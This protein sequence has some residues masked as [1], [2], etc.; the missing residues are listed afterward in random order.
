MSAAALKKK[1]PGHGEAAS[2]AG[3]PQA[4]GEAAAAGVPAFLGGVAGGA[5]T[6]AFLQR[7]P[8]AAAIPLPQSEEEAALGSGSVQ[9]LPQDPFPDSGEEDDLDE[10][11]AAIQTKLEINTPG[12]AYEREADRVAAAVTGKGAAS[13]AVSAASTAP[14]LQRKCANCDAPLTEE[15]A[16]SECSGKVQRKQSASGAPSP[17]SRVAQVVA[18]P[19]AGRP[20]PDATRA[21]IEAELG[22]DLSHVRVHDDNAAGEASSSIQAKAFTHKNH[23]WLGSGQSADD[24]ALMAHEA[25][26]TVQQS[27]GGSDPDLVQ[28]A[29]ADHQHPEDGAAPKARMDAEIANAEEDGEGGDW[30]EGDPLPAVDQSERQSKAGSLEGQARP[31]TDRPAQEAPKVEQASNEVKQEADSPTEDMVDG[32]SETPDTES[33]EGQDAPAAAADPIGEAMA[34]IAGLPEPEAPEPIEA[35]AIAQPVDGD[36]YPLP[37]EAG[38][39]AMVQA[40][41]AQLQVSREAAHGLRR[42]A[43]QQRANAILLRGNLALADKHIAEAETGLETSHGHMEVRR[44]GLSE[45]DN[46]HAVSEQKAQT[47]AAEAPGIE[48]EASEAE[49]ESGPIASESS[50]SAAQAQA[51][52]PDDPEGAEKSAE[53]SGQMSSVAGDS[54]SMDQAASATKQRAI[55]LQQD[56]AGAQAGNA[57]AQASIEAA[58]GSADQIDAKLVEMDGQT[59]QARGELEPLTGKP[60][61]AEAE[62]QRL[63]DAAAQ[64]DGR[65]EAMAQQLHDAQAQFVA[66]MSRVPGSDTLAEENEGQIQRTEDPAAPTSAGAAAPSAGSGEAPQAFAPRG[67]EGRRKVELPTFQIGPPLTE[68]QRQR[69]AEAAARAE[70]RRR[71]RIENLQNGAHGNFSEMGALDKAGIALDF[72]LSDAFEGASNIKWPDWSA[73][74]VGRALLNIVD[75]RGPLNG[76]IGGLSMIASGGLNLF[77]MD[78]WSRDP[79]GNLLKSAADIATGITVILGS[80]VALLGLVTAISAAIAVLMFWVPPVSAAAAAVMTWCAGA[81]ATVGGWT[82]SVGLLALYFQGLLII[83]NLIDVMTAE[84]AEELVQNSEQLSDDFAQTGNI[85]MQMGTAYLGAKGGPGMVD[86]IATNGVRSVARSEV[87]DAL[88]DAALEVAVGEDIAGVVGA[89]RMAR[90]VSQNMRG[91]GGGGSGAQRGDDGTAPRPADADSA[92]AS[93]DVAPASVRPDADA[94]APPPPREDNAQPVSDTPARDAPVPNSQLPAGDAPS[95]NL[96]QGDAP[97]PSRDMDTTAPQ[98]AQPRSDAESD[99]NASARTDQP[100]PDQ[101]PP[102][103]QQPNLDGGGGAD[104]PNAQPQIPRADADGGARQRSDADAP[105]PDADSAVPRSQGEGANRSDGADDGPR[106][107]NDADPNAPRPDSEN[108]ASLRESAASK[109]LD[110]LSPAERRAEADQANA[111]PRRDIGDPRLEAIGFESRTSIDNG[112]DYIRSQ[113]HGVVCRVAN[114]KC[115]TGTTA[116]PSTA[117]PAVKSEGGSPQPEV[118]AQVR[119]ATNGETESGPTP[120]PPTT[121]TDAGAQAPRNDSELPPQTPEGTASE[122]QRGESEATESQNPDGNQSTQTPDPVNG[123]TRTPEERRREIADEVYELKGDITRAKIRDLER[124]GYVVAKAGGDGD[125]TSI[126]V[127]PGNPN[128]LPQVQ[129]RQGRIVDVEGRTPRD[130]PI[131][132]E[133]SDFT[134]R[135]LTEE[136]GRWGTKE[137]RAQNYEIIQHLRE[138]GH[139]RQ[140]DE[141]VPDLDAGRMYSAPS[142]PG[143]GIG[144]EEYI[145]ASGS[146]G[147]SYVDITVNAPDGSTVRVQTVTTT[148]GRTPDAGETAA[149]DRI[150]SAFPNDT[151]I[152]V[153]KGGRFPEDAIYWGAEGE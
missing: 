17:T 4:E 94:A 137:T 50:D 56:A 34:A 111:A 102:P 110:S 18:S 125:V 134:R 152:L 73:D 36:G 19:G 66:D 68:E 91:G 109:P 26:H 121:D 51:N 41:A 85:A 105:R 32:Q 83:K 75:P 123:A 54:A 138:H 153:P 77:D 9:R 86:D 93:G 120:T 90:G 126:R 28:R 80:I 143:G 127:P 150:Q 119:D 74:S 39:E 149:A 148:D 118:E 114:M 96:V 71:S 147:A 16:C 108:P 58:K 146:R 53:T 65:V 116:E 135:Y 5:S 23:I 22:R 55:Q 24:A 104:R 130:V 101:V 95:P 52:T 64:A 81:T 129:M 112:K 25:T 48:A 106:R 29:P 113:E 61:A 141:Q 133:M 70:Q 47:V 45:A 46:A 122:R 44:Q 88:S 14:A 42:K 72:M 99:A 100:S 10:A 67:Y 43:K 1:P 6:P 139:P 79:L 97:T 132:D 3:K 33:S 11:G 20:I 124:R 98:P 38:N 69:Q 78:Q 7:A 37:P 92:P 117:T 12:D 144:P 142:R 31:D 103:A 2:E 15:G 76:I 8:A 115:E 62:A 89:A 82:I 13:P 35:P 49:G 151:L 136:G 145:P 21:P 107:Q 59:A 140:S 57:Q 30:E 87:V 128:G 84:T 40:V 63:D 131:T 27:G 60:D